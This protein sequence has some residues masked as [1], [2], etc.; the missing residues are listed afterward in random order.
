MF[1][2]RNSQCFEIVISMINDYVWSDIDFVS[3]IV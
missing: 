2:F 3:L 1:E